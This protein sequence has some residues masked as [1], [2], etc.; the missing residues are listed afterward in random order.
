MSYWHITTHEY[1]IIDYLKL[2]LNT[3]GFM[4][5][6]RTYSV[7]FFQWITIAWIKVNYLSHS[8]G[9]LSL[10]GKKVVK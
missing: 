9:Q 3:G 10:V 6:M 2:F 4:R 5:S 1:N 7:T 8:D